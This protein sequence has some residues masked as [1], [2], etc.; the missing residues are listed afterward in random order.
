MSEEIKIKKIKCTI[1]PNWSIDEIIEIARENMFG[2]SNDGIC[3]KCGDVQDGCEPDA[4]NYKCHSCGE[5]AV[6]GAEE[7]LLTSGF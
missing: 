5:F 3:V 1:P 6:F 2:M 7:I 4:Q